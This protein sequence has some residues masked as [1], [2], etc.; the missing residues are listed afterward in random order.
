MKIGDLVRHKNLG[1]HGIVIGTDLE[2]DKTFRYVEIHWIQ[3]NLSP[4]WFLDHNLLE[5]V[6]ENR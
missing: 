6:G 5:V 2:I 3:G 4:I 1:H